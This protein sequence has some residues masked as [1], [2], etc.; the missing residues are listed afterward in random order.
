M[1]DDKD[2]FIEPEAAHRAFE[3]GAAGQ[4]VD[5][6]E[7][8]EVDAVR[9]EGALNLPLSRL[10]ELAGLAKPKREKAAP[11]RAGRAKAG[12]AGGPSR[13]QRGRRGR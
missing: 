6:R 2:I 5:V 7:V 13:A 3:K 12:S 1:S 4:L 8:F 11:S 9:I 10:R